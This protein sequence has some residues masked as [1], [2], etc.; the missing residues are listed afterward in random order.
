MFHQEWCCVAALA[1][2]YWAKAAL[3]V[4]RLVAGKNTTVNFVHF[5]EGKAGATHH[6]G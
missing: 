6:A 1:Q 2:S 5:L 4:E 3:G